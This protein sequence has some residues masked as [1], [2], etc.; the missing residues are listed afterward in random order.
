METNSVF[1]IIKCMYCV[2]QTSSKVSNLY[3]WLPVDRSYS[4]DMLPPIVLSMISIVGQALNNAPFKMAT[5]LFR[6]IPSHGNQVSVELLWEIKKNK[7]PCEV[8]ISWQACTH[9]KYIF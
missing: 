6:F 3:S 4:D 8:V 1:D 5:I 9:G 7:M 2:A